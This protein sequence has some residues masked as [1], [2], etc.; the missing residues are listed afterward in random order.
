VPP[1]GYHWW[2]IDALSDDGHNGLTIIG[3][4][5]SVFSPYYLR[6]RKNGPADPENHCAINVALYGRKRRWAMTERSKTQ[7][8][9]SAD[10]LRIGP[11]SMRWNGTDLEIEIR[12]TCVPLPLSLQGTVTMH[13]ET[14]Y[15]HPVLLNANGQHH[16][17]AVAPKARITVSMKRPALQWQGTAY[18]DMNWGSEALETGFREWTWARTNHQASTDV[19][20]DFERRDGSRDAFMMRFGDT[21]EKTNCTVPRHALPKG[22]WRMNRALPS[23]T[24]PQLI[25]TLEDAPFYTRNHLRIDESNIMHESLSLDR[26][27]NPITQ[28]MLPFR[29]PRVR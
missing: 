5:G 22:F 9:R 16:W 6:A 19:V 23:T 21:V 24:R 17:R 11:S 26:W 8:N 14:L 28:I 3:F 12:E 15:D 7:T 13:A 4:V 2:Y 18:H 10:L 29:M 27:V 25:T 20:Y 1:N